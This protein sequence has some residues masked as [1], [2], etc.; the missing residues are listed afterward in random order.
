MAK[1]KEEL[2]LLATSKE[3]AVSIYQ[4]IHG[5]PAVNASPEKLSGL[6]EPRSNHPLR[7]AMWKDHQVVHNYG[8]KDGQRLV[9][10][11][12]DVVFKLNGKNNHKPGR[13]D[14]AILTPEGNMHEGYIAEAQEWYKD[15]FIALWSVAFVFHNV[16]K[17]NRVAVVSIEANFPQGIPQDIVRKQYNSA[18]N[19]RLPLIELA[20]EYGATVSIS[21]DGKT[22]QVPLDPLIAVQLIRDRVLTKEWQ[23]QMQTITP[24]RVVRDEWGT[25]RGLVTLGLT[26][27]PRE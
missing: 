26:R 23:D 5:I 19:T 14:N 15:P 8:A 24:S 17:L 20:P 25:R 21:N 22:E 7:P 4:E 2:H 16:N 3:S 27:T 6:T 13:E 1:Q 18:M 12:S 10:T 9:V 11:A